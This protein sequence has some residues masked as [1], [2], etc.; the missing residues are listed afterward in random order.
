L[1]PEGPHSVMILPQVHLRNGLGGWSSVLTPPV[2]RGARLYL[3]RDGGAS[4]PLPLSL[5]TFPIAPGGALGASLR[6]AHGRPRRSAGGI[7]IVCYHPPC[8]Y[9]GPPGGFPPRVGAI[10]F[11]VSPA[12][13]ECRRR[14]APPGGGGGADLH[15]GPGW[16]IVVPGLP[17]AGLQ[18][19]R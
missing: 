11:R 12:V 19:L 4:H 6:I 8:R 2:S 1:D 16:F 17:L 9:H 14:P 13:R 3:K 10:G 15:G 5:W 7:Q 18:R